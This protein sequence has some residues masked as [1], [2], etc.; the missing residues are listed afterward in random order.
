MPRWGQSV[1]G[2]ARIFQH[3]C[4]RRRL[5][6]RCCRS[7]VDIRRL[8]VSSVWNTP[9][10]FDA[11]GL[12]DRPSPAMRAL[13]LGIAGGLVAPSSI[14]SSFLA[15]W[16]SWPPLVAQRLT[17]GPGPLPVRARYGAR[18]L[19]RWPLSAA[20]TDGCCGMA[21]RAVAAGFHDQGRRRFVDTRAAV[22]LFLVVSILVVRHQHWPAT[23]LLMSMFA[24]AIR[25]ILGF[26]TAAPC[27]ARLPAGHPG[28]LPAAGRR[29]ARA[30]MNIP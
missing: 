12:A 11:E 29:P 6:C 25:S 27:T 15:R 8:Q 22:Y 30:K 1:I 26:R 21:S 7:F 16:I 28:V 10:M 19:A 24:A 13:V 17:G 20:S 3:G 4:C 2:T 23:P 18:R 5:A 14:L 9:L